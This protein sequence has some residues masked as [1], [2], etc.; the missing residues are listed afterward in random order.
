MDELTSKLELL[1]ALNQAQSKT[2]EYMDTLEKRLISLQNETAELKAKLE[3]AQKNL[4]YYN[5]LNQNQ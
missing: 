1:L 3:Y 2:F 4:D 5:N